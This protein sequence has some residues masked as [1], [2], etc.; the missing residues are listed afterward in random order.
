MLLMPQ[1]HTTMPL[2][3]H[4]ARH[5]VTSE[6]WEADNASETAASISQEKIMMGKYV[7]LYL[8]TEVYH[9]YRRTGYPNNLPAPADAVLNAIPRRIPYPLDERLY[10]GN[11]MPAGQT[12]SSRVWWDVQ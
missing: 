11:N 9:D 10:N 8:Q 1:L 7:A 2:R 3:L 4:L 5:G 6:A 12:L